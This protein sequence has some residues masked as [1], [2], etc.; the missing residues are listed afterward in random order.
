ME[1]TNYSYVKVS[2]G[3][4]FTLC[5]MFGVISC[6]RIDNPIR[7]GG[8]SK[9][10]TVQQAV[11]TVV[12]VT[13]ANPSDVTAALGAIVTNEAVAAAA[14]K[15]EPIKVTVA[16]SG[17]S[18]GAADNKITIPQKNGA[19][20]EISFATAPA[21]T[22]SNALVLET[23]LGAGAIPGAANNNLTVTMPPSSGL[24][25]T[26]ELPTTTVTLKTD[27][28]GNV[29]YQDVIAKTARSTI[30]IDKGVTIK[31]HELVGGNI[32]VKDGGA[33]E[34]LAVT[35]KGERGGMVCLGSWWCGVSFKG[36]EPDY[37]IKKEDSS[38][39]LPKHVIVRKGE[40]DHITAWTNGPSDEA[41]ESLT[42]G[43]DVIVSM[44]GNPRYKTIKGDGNNE[45]HVQGG[46]DNHGT[47]DVNDDEYFYPFASNT[48]LVKNFAIK[49]EIDDD[50]VLDPHIYND[51]A[52]LIINFN[53]VENNGSKTFTFENCNFDDN[54]QF[55]LSA[56]RIAHYQ[57]YLGFVNPN[58]EHPTRFNSLEDLLNAGIPNKIV[59]RDERGGYWIDDDYG[60]EN[61]TVSD[62]TCI[63]EFK[64]C[65][66][67]GEDITINNDMSTEPPTYQSNLKFTKW[68][69]WNRDNNGIKFKVIVDGTLYD[70]DTRWYADNDPRNGTIELRDPNAAPPGPPAGD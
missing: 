18:T 38:Y 3:L 65:K 45:L 23:S 20:I 24:A 11:A 33:I 8:G 22:G 2:V 56:L 27:G 30:I 42:A 12:N 44:L 36:A 57:Y 4:I 14:A 55:A 43:E 41:I 13:G 60:E 54:I 66:I 35:I 39:Y 69:L 47:E 70:P 52:N 67:G 31:E 64:N 29:V 59:K 21:G 5:M 16:G 40:G 61:P 9:N 37:E 32:T 62:F 50:P 28:S 53:A 1:K 63:L 6:D 17:V 58:D 7:Y 34:T 48:D 51:V 49:A 19:N 68:G 26:I 10:P 25:V 46:I 15:G